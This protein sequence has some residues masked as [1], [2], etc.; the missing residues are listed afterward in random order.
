MGPKIKYSEKGL[1]STVAYKL[2]KDAPVVYALEGAV[3]DAGS[4][5]DWLTSLGMSYSGSDKQSS[6]LDI[7]YTNNVIL[8]PSS[9]GCLS[10]YW[11]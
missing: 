11:R 2:G 6:T 7:N 3:K 9:S 1:L 4:L 5:V 8:V 10:P